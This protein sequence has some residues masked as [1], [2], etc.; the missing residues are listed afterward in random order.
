MVKIAILGLSNCVTKNGW[1]P[2]YRELEHEAEINNISLG[3]TV[4]S[5]G[6][7]RFIQEESWLKDA[8]YCY[9]D[10]NTVATQR[11]LNK[12]IS[13]EFCISCF[14]ALLE[15]LLTRTRCTPIVLLF[16]SRRSMQGRIPRPLSASSW[17]IQLCKLYNVPYIDI[18]AL[19]W[20]VFPPPFAKAF[21]KDAVHYSREFSAVLA[22][23]LKEIRPL[24]RQQFERQ[25]AD[26]NPLFQFD[27]AS[28]LGVIQTDCVRE[29]RGTVLIKKDCYLLDK[30]KRLN[31][32]V[33]TMDMCSMLASFTP[34]ITYT[35]IS[36]S[37]IIRLQTKFRMPYF[38][39][40]DFPEYLSANTNGFEITC[41]KKTWNM[42][43][44]DDR[45]HDDP[46]LKD[47]KVG[48]T[49]VADF[50]LCAKDTPHKTRMLLEKIA[51]ISPEESFL[52][53]EH[54]AF[55]RELLKS[56]SMPSI[57]LQKKISIIGRTAEFFLKKWLRG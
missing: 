8:D 23:F 7:L 17:M 47:M 20:R 54:H 18:E 19:F 6:M 28:N 16:S 51:D 57:P 42:E 56:Q 32:K 3:D 24:C 15:A 41:D 40:R 38:R 10:F 31:L 45:F 52:S 44:L 33:T 9:I 1:V 4:T 46:S 22:R 50:L 55:F 53:E 26:I 39:T 49:G 34:G 5:Y 37:M 36:G 11:I 12:E 27:T 25:K 48:P 2:I 35:Y 43:I 21:F 14:A 13:P 30:G 29:T